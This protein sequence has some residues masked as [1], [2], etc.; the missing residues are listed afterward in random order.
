MEAHKR[1]GHGG[2]EVYTLG[3]KAFG[4]GILQKCNFKKGLQ[5]NY[6]NMEVF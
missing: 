5:T 4:R 6:K 2:A 3:T 1:V